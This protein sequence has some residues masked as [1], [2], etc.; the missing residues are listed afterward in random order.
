MLLIQSHPGLN[1]AFSGIVPFGWQ[2]VLGGTLSVAMVVS[3]L[4]IIS[5]MKMG[6][7][8]ALSAEFIA[9]IWIAIGAI[10]HP[11]LLSVDG[12]FLSGVEAFVVV[13]LASVRLLKHRDLS[14]LLW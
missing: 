13:C 7:M 3:S 12:F 9:I 8:V 10:L 14:D 2:S 5:A 6:W 4:L 11:V 1:L